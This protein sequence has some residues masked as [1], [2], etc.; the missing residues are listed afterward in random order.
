MIEKIGKPSKNAMFDER[1]TVI[2][3]KINEIV[4][5]MNDIEGEGEYEAPTM[6][7][8]LGADMKPD[9]EQEPNG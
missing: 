2:E 9:N 8:A 4:E 3:G 7:E 5:F 1:L 6:A